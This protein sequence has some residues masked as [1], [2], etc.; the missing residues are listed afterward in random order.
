MQLLKHFNYTRTCFRETLHCRSYLFRC[1]IVGAGPGLVE[2]SSEVVQLLLTAL[3]K[4]LHF[5]IPALT[6]SLPLFLPF[7]N[8]LQKRGGG[9]SVCQNVQCGYIIC[10]N[11]CSS[12]LTRSRASLSLLTSC[13][14]SSMLLILSSVSLRFCFSA[15]YWAWVLSAAS[16]SSETETQHHQTRVLGSDVI[17]EWSQ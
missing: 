16:F 13:I 4:L 2:F 3:A 17:L 14:S 15:R 7:Q 10:E 9:D 11:V 6:F 1:S 12:I 5:L 8:S